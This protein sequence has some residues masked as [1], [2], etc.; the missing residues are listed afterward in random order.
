MEYGSGDQSSGSV[1]IPQEA[2]QEDSEMTTVKA[3][4]EK[5]SNAIV[6]ASRLKVEVGD[7]RAAVDGLRQEVEKVRSQN[8]WLDEQLTNVRG[9]RDKATGELSAAREELGD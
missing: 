2:P 3:V 4:F 8:Q 1:N 7:L 9:Q 6:D 5:A